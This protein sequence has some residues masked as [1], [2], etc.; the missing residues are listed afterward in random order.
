MFK[1]SRCQIVVTSL[2]SV[3][4][5]IVEFPGS[6]CSM[7]RLCLIG[8]I[9]SIVVGSFFSVVICSCFSTFPDTHR[10]YVR[11]LPFFLEVGEYYAYD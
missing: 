6:L 7:K 3:L 2:G 8:A 11:L 10:A 9:L 4:G 5:W 1:C